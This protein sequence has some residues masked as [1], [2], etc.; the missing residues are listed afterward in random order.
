M[1]A[2]CKTMCGIAGI[3]RI[4][5]VVEESELWQLCRALRHRGPE[6]EG[7]WCHSSGHLGFAH[8]RL[9]IVDISPA[10]RQPMHSPTGRSCI[11]FNGEIYNFRKLRREA[12]QRGW[13]FR[14]NSDTEVILAL[15]ELYG[16]DCLRYLH[17][18]FAFALWDEAEGRLWLVR[19]R[20]GIKPLYYFWDGNCLAFASE[21]PALQQLRGFDARLDVTA[22]WDF[23]TYHYI[24]PP[25]SIYRRIAKLEAGRWVCLDT[26]R[27]QLFSQRYWRV[28]EPAE[29]ERSLERALE[30]LDELLTT[31]VAEHL[32]A[33]VPLGAFLSGGVDSSLVVAYARRQ[34]PLRA[35]T[36]DVDGAVWSERHFAEAV[37]QHLKV[38]HSIV[39][40]AAEKAPAAVE[41]F[42]RVYGEPFGDTSGLAVLAIAQAARTEVKAVLSGDGADELFAGYIRSR[43]DIGGSGF[44]WWRSR[45]WV[46]W[47]L[48]H[49]PTKRGERWLRKLLPAEEQIVR[50]GVWLEFAQKQRLLSPDI[51]ALLPAD[52]DELWFVRRYAFRQYSPLR[53]RLLLELQTWLPEKMLTKVDRASMA[54]GLEVRV[55]FVDHRLVEWVCRVPEWLL[56]NPERGGKWLLKRLLE[57]YLPTSLVYRPKKGFSIPVHRWLQQLAWHER[58]RESRFWKEGFFHPALFHR[59]DIRSPVTQF[60]LLVL[61]LWSDQNR[62]IL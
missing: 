15:Y 40:V 3:Y 12:A 27:A 61:A 45:R 19:D 7:V 42:V 26:R 41:R 14:S 47:L 37:A 43:A 25:K 9:A 8:T 51:V 33:D 54:V 62:W 39:R 21:L 13:S 48:S 53:Q 56:W 1:R 38:E 31:V 6:G 57:K 18:M 35:F 28:P 4:G 50:V 16:I 30:E 20:L 49:M 46:P 59:A 24:P 10:A 36:V 34:Q 44:P 2:Q 29:E 5:G 32:V 52:Y 17:G 60:L 23:L 58:I 55:P 22:V 11:V